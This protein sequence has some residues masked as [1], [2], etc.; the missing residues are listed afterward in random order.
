MKSLVIFFLLFSTMLFNGCEQSVRITNEIFNSELNIDYVHKAL[1]QKKWGMYLALFGELADYDMNEN[2][3]I[4]AI[5]SYS[6]LPLTITGTWTLNNVTQEYVCT[7][8][9]NN[10]TWATKF[11]FTPLAINA[12]TRS[13]FRYNLD[14]KYSIFYTQYDEPESG[15]TSLHLR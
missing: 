7:F 13:G 6:A 5:T 15:T 1:L 8:E 2:G 10:P 14:V 9:H 12:S 3:D 4:T 11:V